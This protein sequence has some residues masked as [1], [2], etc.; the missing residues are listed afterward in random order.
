MLLL[1]ALRPIDLKLCGRT[2][3]LCPPGSCHVWVST[4]EP[5][6]IK[7]NAGGVIR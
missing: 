6:D 2:P 4:S 3:D 1:L 7:P 5:L